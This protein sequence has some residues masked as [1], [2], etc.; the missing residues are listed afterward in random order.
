[1]IKIILTFFITSNCF[2]Q[3]KTNDIITDYH[4]V[5]RT[6]ADP[7]FYDHIIEYYNSDLNKTAK[8]DP[9][10]ISYKT[11]PVFLNHD[12][13]KS[14]DL[15]KNDLKYICYFFKE[16]KLNVFAINVNLWNSLEKKD[17][18]ELFFT[19]YHKCR[20]KTVTNSPKSP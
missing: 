13:E 9:T 11:V 4:D 1:M 8:K 2:A 12:L 3:F 16:E 18:D 10:L 17:R 7:A 5:F 19:N 6:K 14:V 20:F 15:T